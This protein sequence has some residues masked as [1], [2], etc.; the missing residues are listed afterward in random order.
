MERNL[1]LEWV[2]PASLD[3]NPLNWRRHPKEQLEALSY[4]IEKVGYAGALLYNERTQRLI[5][6]HGRKGLLI[7]QGVAEV[8][9]LIGDWSEEQEK[10]ILA[11]L[12]PIAMQAEFDKRVFEEI[13]KSI[14]QPD[15]AITDLFSEVLNLAIASGRGDNEFD[16]AYY[17]DMFMEDGIKRQGE[18][19]VCPHCGQKL[20]RRR[21]ASQTSPANP[22]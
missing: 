2:D 20:P 8:P 1:R 10:L 17:E 7:K 15:G 11:T 5:D 13:V 14:P 9:V 3:D 6:G 16:S 19:E 18:R 22:S 4:T 21:S 12:D